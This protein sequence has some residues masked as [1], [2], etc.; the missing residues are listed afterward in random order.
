METTKLSVSISG[1]GMASVWAKQDLQANISGFGMV[2][3]RGNPS[4]S[5]IISGLGSVRQLKKSEQLALG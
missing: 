1:Q 2:E 5:H 4:V 3:Y